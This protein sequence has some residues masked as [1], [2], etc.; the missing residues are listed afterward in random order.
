MSHPLAVG[1]CA[2]AHIVCAQRHRSSAARINTPRMA[3][4]ECHNTDGAKYYFT[5]LYAR[6]NGNG[7]GPLCQNTGWP[8]NSNPGPLCQNTDMAR[9]SK[10]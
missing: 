4:R 3:Y 5:N 2:G 8:G 10:F 7:P 9:L 1:H 6:E